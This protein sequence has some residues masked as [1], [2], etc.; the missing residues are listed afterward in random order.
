[1]RKNLYILAVLAVLM[2]SFSPT[3]S[4]TLQLTLSSG[5]TTQ[6]VSNAGSP[7]IFIGAVG[8]W[9]VNV[10]TGI[11]GSNPLLHFNS[12]DQLG[13]PAGTG[14]NALTITLTSFGLNS[15]GSAVS[16]DS[17]I[18]PVLAGQHSLTYQAYTDPTNGGN[19]TNTAG[20][21]LS[22]SNPTN[23]SV[24]LSGATSGG[25]VAANT[26]YSL[27]QVV[28]ISGTAAG[29]TSFDASI[30]AVPEPA[31]VVLLGGVLVAA[32]TKLRRGRN[33]A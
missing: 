27:S 10:T 32:F 22:F 29:T 19:L 23:T 33:H 26:L 8:N 18:G 9:I 12:V 6:T 24:S 4:A 15:G 13:T 17:V 1:M 31:T 7:V 11:S 14:T 5:G 25:F 16:F 20:S 28:V 3:A 30:E 21:L 2:M